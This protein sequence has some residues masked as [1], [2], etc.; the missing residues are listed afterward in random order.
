[1]EQIAGVTADLRTMVR[2]NKY[3]REKEEDERER[4][5]LEDEAQ[6]RKK[7]YYTKNTQTVMI[8]SWSIAI[9][10]AIM[11]FLVYGDSQP[12]LFSFATK[13]AD[14]IKALYDMIPW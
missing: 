9:L 10:I 1:M 6:K 3:D 5:A 4:K 14:S 7:K 2:Q 12:Q 13:V 8:A 11:L